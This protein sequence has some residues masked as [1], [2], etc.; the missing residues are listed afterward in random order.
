ME[1]AAHDPDWARQAETEIEMLRR[2]LP[3]LT[4]QWHHI[5]ST[6]VPGLI[7]KPILDLLLETPELEALDARSDAMT[8][9]GYEVMGAYGIPGRRYFRKRDG[10]GRRSHHLHAFETG[11]AHAVRH[12]AFRDYLRTHGDEAAAY[13]ALKTRLLAE[14]RDWDGYIEGKDALV[15]EIEARALRWAASH[16]KCPAP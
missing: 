9:C 11:S 12:L 7:A 13:G 1:L 16:E 2:A 8:A 4:C 10:A 3:G 15:K 14:G 5:G 6:A